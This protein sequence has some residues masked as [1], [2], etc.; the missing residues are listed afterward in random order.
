VGGCPWIWDWGKARGLRGLVGVAAAGGEVRPG[1]ARTVV[2]V[3]VVAEAK[4]ASR[5]AWLALVRSERGRVVEL[6]ALV[7]EG[8]RER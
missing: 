5:R 6:A 3:R 4:G 7:R 8:P 2:A 1:G